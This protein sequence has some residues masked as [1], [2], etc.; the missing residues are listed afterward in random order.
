MGGWTENVD[1]REHSGVDWHGLGSIW[2]NTLR[3][4]DHLKWIDDE[5]LPDSV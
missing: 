5:R 1:L 2:G 4:F 3:L